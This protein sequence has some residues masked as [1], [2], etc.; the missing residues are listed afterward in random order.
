[1]SSK[2]RWWLAHEL[3]DSLHVGDLLGEVV[4]GVEVKNVAL[5][6]R[7]PRRKPFL[8]TEQGVTLILH[9]LPLSKMTKSLPFRG[10]VL[11]FY[12]F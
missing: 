11:K 5:K 2:E 3:C 10:V 6:P 9:F 4:E 8:L 12:L 1:M 7:E